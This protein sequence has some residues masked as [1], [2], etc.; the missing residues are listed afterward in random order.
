MNNQNHTTE[1]LSFTLNQNIYG[2]NVSNVKEIIRFT[3]ITPLPKSDSLI[4]GYIM[5]RNE[6][7]TVIDLKRCLSL[8]TKE[9]SEDKESSRY[10]IICSLNNHTIAF[11]ADDVQDIKSFSSEDFVEPGKI[12]QTEENMI[13]S[14]IKTTQHIMAV[15]NYENL[16]SKIN[17][18]DVEIN[19]ET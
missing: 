11:L 9:P 13:S 14:L 18:S 5:P 10:F 7:I 8:T 19:T 12:L 6:A 4:W 2:I 16:I 1:I 3:K 17:F 15:L